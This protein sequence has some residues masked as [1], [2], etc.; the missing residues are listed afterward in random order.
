MAT[1]RTSAATPIPSQDSPAIDNASV[2]GFPEIR[3]IRSVRRYTKKGRYAVYVGRLPRECTPKSAVELPAGLDFASILLSPTSV[4]FG[5]RV[6]RAF[7]Q[8]QID[9]GFPGRRWAL[10]AI[11]PRATVGAQPAED[12][13]VHDF[14]TAC[15]LPSSDGSP[16]AISQEMGGGDTR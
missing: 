3:G 9:N 4:G 16:L 14:C 8:H 7:N 6:C 1:I 12:E 11:R 2:T 15:R 10:L 13:A 5:G